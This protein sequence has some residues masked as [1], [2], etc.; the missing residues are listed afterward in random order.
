VDVGEDE[1]IAG[2]HHTPPASRALIAAA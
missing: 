1:R 2:P